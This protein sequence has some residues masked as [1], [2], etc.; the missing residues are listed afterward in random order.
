MCADLAEQNAIEMVMR[1]RLCLDCAD[2]CTAT[3]GVTSRQTEYNANVT[4]PLLEACVAI[5]KN[6]AMSASGM[7]GCTGTAGSA[8][9][10]ADAGAGLPGVPGRH[11]IADR[12]FRR[13]LLSH[14]PVPRAAD[15]YSRARPGG[16]A[17]T[18]LVFIA[19]QFKGRPRGPQPQL[20][21]GPSATR[22][23]SGVT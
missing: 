20:A 11:E 5:C 18:A 17:V 9:R 13:A 3:V 10:P 19:A 1:I 15:D 4:R 8:P 7:P 22:R 16:L 21:G 6:S 2:I 12:P 14:R 23:G